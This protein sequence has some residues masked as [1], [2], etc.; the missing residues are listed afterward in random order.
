MSSA[1]AIAATTFLLKDLLDNR[2]IAQGLT[3]SLGEVSVTALP[4]DRVPVGAE[5]RSQLNL[6]LYRI[7]PYT[8]WRGGRVGNDAANGRVAAAAPPLA[9][10]LHYLLAAYGEHDFHAELLLG[11]AMQVL[12]QTPVLSAATIQSVLTTGV[13]AGSSSPLRAALAAASVNDG[14]AGV[15]IEPEFLSNEETSKLWSALQARYRP[16]A[17]YK[18]SAI[19]LDDGE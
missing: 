17:S 4:P 9:L 1:L 11:V 12:H 7:T 8:G 6:F 19:V 18:V 14:G 13:S 2:L 10:D 3:S 5:E 15:T 16:S